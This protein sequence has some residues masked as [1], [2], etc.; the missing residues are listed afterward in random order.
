MNRTSVIR[1]TVGIPR[2]AWAVM[3]AAGLAVGLATA[4]IVDADTAI[5]LDGTSFTNSGE[6]RWTVTSQNFGTLTTDLVSSSVMGSQTN[7]PVANTSCFYK[8]SGGYIQMTDSGTAETSYALGDFTVEFFFRSSSTAKYAGYDTY[9]AWHQNAWMMQFG[10]DG[11][12]TLKDWNWGNSGS[13]TLTGPGICDGVWHHI[14]FV[15]VRATNRWL[16]YVDYKLIGSLNFA[17]PTTQAPGLLD[18]NS[19]ASSPQLPHGDSQFDEIR[20]TKRALK[21]AEFLTTPECAAVFIDPFAGVGTDT[22]LY[23]S[24]FV[25][26]VASQDMNVLRL[27]DSTKPALTLTYSTAPAQET[28]GDFP[29]LYRSPV[30]NAT[31]VTNTEAYQFKGKGRMIMTDLSYLQNDFTLEFFFR[32]D[33]PSKV[34]GD[35]DDVYLVHQP[36]ANYYFRMA[37]GTIAAAGMVTARAGVSDAP[38]TRNLADG[39][40]HHYAMTWEKST[41]T[42]RAYID[43]AL[44]AQQTPAA[45]FWP[46][47]AEPGTDNH[48]LYIGAGSWG[49]GSWHII[50]QGWYDEIRLTGRR[51]DPGEF[52][53]NRTYPMY[54]NTLAHLNFDLEDR[55]EFLNFRSFGGDLRFDH[56][57]N[58]TRNITGGI[59][60]ATNDVP[61]PSF[62]ANAQTSVANVNGRAI[63]HDI[64]SY[65]GGN[66]T[67]SGGGYIL[68]DPDRRILPGSFTAEMFFRTDTI[69]SPYYGFLMR[70]EGLWQA[71]VSNGGKL[72][73]W[74][75]AAGKDY[76]GTDLVTDNL[77]HHLA[78]SYDQDLKTFS[79]YFDYRLFTRYENIDNPIPSGTTHPERLFVGGGYR[80]GNDTTWWALSGVCN[81]LWYDEVRVTAAPLKVTEFLTLSSLPAD[82]VRLW[83]RFEDASLASGT[84]HGQYAL[85]AETAGAVELK[86]GPQ[87]RPSR[88][89]YADDA[90]AA[91]ANAYGAYLNGGTLTYRGEGVLDLPTATTEFF[92]RG[93][94]T[95]AAPVAAFSADDEGWSLTAD[96]RLS[97]A[98]GAASDSLTLNVSPCDGRW[99]HV[100]I[101]TEVADGE[102]VVRAYVDHALAGSTT[103]AETLSF[104]KPAS[105]VFGSATFVGGID[106]VR[107]T[108]TALSAAQLMHCDPPPGFTVIVR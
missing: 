59:F 24:G 79:V 39:A 83:G 80:Q 52:L 89:V 58:I 12:F 76:I 3:I 26:P 75:G 101:V 15:Q 10:S 60:T 45:D 48:A 51:L 1:K 72:G 33:D 65:S 108:K 49:S 57:Q 36:G 35:N 70:E 8:S 71:F 53:A 88:R 64:T 86:L 93:T 37:G 38:Q 73:F 20:I 90:A 77:W 66:N 7:A 28:P 95:G 9:L 106:E 18:F 55:T 87:A 19:Y 54:A 34:A 14:A 29:A 47:S 74:L 67:A 61:G 103:L 99:H 30:W 81:R 62:L 107:V 44:C 43:H 17:I 32:A 105:L 84:P 104:A 31:C 16:L 69:P 50:G 13:G 92:V 2:R 96:G 102:T 22:I 63:Y 100:A 23:V 42:M 41:L 6:S 68:F 21:P 91:T 40:W 46:V 85:T 5:Y 25:P 97:I 94:G 11:K 56:Q 27:Y 82:A 78:V 4:G 98:A